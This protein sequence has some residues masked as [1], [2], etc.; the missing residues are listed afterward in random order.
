VDVD[1]QVLQADGMVHST[2]TYP[3]SIMMF[4][5]CATLQWLWWRQKWWL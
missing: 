3:L 4:W 2:S 5:Y 1:Q